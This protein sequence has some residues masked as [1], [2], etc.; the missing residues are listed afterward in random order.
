MRPPM[1]LPPTPAVP[2]ASR[3]LSPRAI[4]MLG[5]AG[6]MMATAVISASH[7]PAATPEAGT[8]VVQASVSPSP[9]A[10]AP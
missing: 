4:V 5:V 1:P 6:I 7:S 8:T 2:A 3:H 9:E 10:T